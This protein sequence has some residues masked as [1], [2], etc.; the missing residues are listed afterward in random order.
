MILHRF[1][2]GVVAALAG[3]LLLAG[4][5]PAQLTASSARSTPSYTSA[6]PVAAGPLA[7]YSGKYPDPVVTPY[8]RYGYP[9]YGYGGYMAGNYYYGPSTIGA[10]SPVVEVPSSVFMTSINYPG[11]YG[12]ITMGVPAYRYVT[13]PDGF[14]YYG[15]PSA[16]V[17]SPRDVT[18]TPV[19]PAGAA[20]L[21]AKEPAHLN[22]QLPSEASLWIQGQEMNET[23]GFREFV[24]P[25]LTPGQRYT[26]EVQARWN[27]NGKAVT[28]TRTV[29]IRAGQRVDV[30]FTNPPPA[31]EGTATMRSAGP[32]SATMRAHPL[33]PPP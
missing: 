32:G 6:G 5:A 24:S 29:P 19:V 2:L 21:T 12:L 26:Y 3:G 10:Y 4:P 15:I 20:A 13:R 25:P 31:P 9:G 11:Q 16:V 1:T 14:N 8:A 33:A 17:Q 18:I 30:D 28:Q 27:E 22:V 7:G 23:G